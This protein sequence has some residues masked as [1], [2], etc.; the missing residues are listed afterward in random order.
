[1]L[2]PMALP[3]RNFQL[4]RAFALTGAVAIALFSILM[5]SLLS[6]FLEHELLERDAETSRD[7]VQS[8]VE[9][10]RIEPYFTE[11]P[12]KSPEV[13]EF[14]AH[15]SAMPGVLRTNVY[16]RDRRVHWSSRPEMIGRQFDHNPELDAALGG[17]AVAHRD[18]QGPD[19]QTKAEHLLLDARADEFV[20]NYLPVRQQADGQVIGVVELYRRPVAML[21]SL[22]K[23][24]QLV[25]VSALG[26]GVFLFLCLLWFVRHADATL[27]E[28]QRRLVERETLARVGEL[29]GAVAHSIRNPLGSIRSSAELHGELGELPPGLAESLMRHVDRIE[30]LVRT[31]LGYA[32]QGADPPRLA[33]ADL[34]RVVRE[35]SERRAAEAVRQGKPYHADLCADSLPVAADAALLAEVVDALLNNALEATQAGQAIHLSLQRGPQQARLSVRDQG[36]GLSPAQQGSLFKPF[37]TTKPQG[38]GMGLALARQTAE[39]LGGQL[40]AEPNTPQGLSFTLSLPLTDTLPPHPPPA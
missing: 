20:E 21:A 8:V 5:A 17:R 13:E 15:L 3:P 25:W 10:Q 14:L 16:G 38:L 9:T 12:A 27:Q 31:L 18:E 26:G 11:Q 2:A 40:L 4:L 7:F 23:G 34:R 29:S 33:A 37:F 35:V 1:M 39:R 36:P 24:Q 22:R 30:H 6:A 19:A 32:Q 28:Q